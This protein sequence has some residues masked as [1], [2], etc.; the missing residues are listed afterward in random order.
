[1]ADVFAAAVADYTPKVK[2]NQA[3]IK[4]LMLLKY[5]LLCKLGFRRAVDDKAL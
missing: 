3:E 5:E 2:D 1:M 4:P